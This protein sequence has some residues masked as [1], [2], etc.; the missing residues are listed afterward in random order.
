MIHAAERAVLVADSS[1][2]G[3]RSLA[4]VCALPELWMVLTDEE[5]PPSGRAAFEPVLRCVPLR[6]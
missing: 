5:L 3:R 4:P 1:K 6:A 2:F